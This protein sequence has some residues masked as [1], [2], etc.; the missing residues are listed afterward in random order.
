LK[1]QKQ[2]PASASE[3][4]PVRAHQHPSGD[5]PV[6]K[7][8]NRKKEDYTWELHNKTIKSNSIP[9]IS[10]SPANRS[11]DNNVKFDTPRHENMK[12]GHSLPKGLWHIICT[13]RF[14]KHTPDHSRN[15]TGEEEMIV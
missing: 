8:R 3:H 9:G 13:Q 1:T 5:R 15:F 11:K 12:P 14:T 6:H 2:Y 7:Q 10:N 4:L